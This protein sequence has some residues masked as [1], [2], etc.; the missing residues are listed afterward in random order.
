[1]KKHATA[2]RDFTHADD[3]IATGDVLL[4]MDAG[5]FRDWSAEGVDLVRE[6]TEA[7]VRKAQGERPAPAKR[8]ATKAARKPKAAKAPAPAATNPAPAE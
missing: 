8:A 6:A 1:M 2:L 7:E 3:N 4:S 5:R